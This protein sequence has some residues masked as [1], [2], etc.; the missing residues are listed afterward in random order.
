MSN[1]VRDVMHEV[2]YQHPTGVHTYGNCLTEGCKLS[3]RGGVYCK[4][5]A[6]A[7]LAEAKDPAFA[8]RFVALIK[9]RQSIQFDIDEMYEESM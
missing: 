7:R 1:K 8:A 6:G 3:A 9:A 2:T 5:C 4:Q